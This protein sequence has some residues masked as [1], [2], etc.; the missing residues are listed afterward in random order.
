MAGKF[1]DRLSGMQSQYADSKN[2]YDSMFGGVK[3]PP[4]QY[5]AR[6]Q[7][8]KIVES[9]SSGKLMIRREHVITEG[10]YAGMIAY[11]NMQLETPMGFTFVRRWVERMGYNCPEDPAEIEELCE[12]IAEDAAL[13]KIQIKHS[14]DFV[15]VSVIEALETETATEPEEPKAKPKKAAEPEED[16][17][18]EAGDDD[19][20][21]AGLFEF[22][23]AQ[24]IATEADDTADVLCERI[25]EYKWPE[26][27]M[28]E[29][30]IKLFDEAG[31][32]DAI[33]RAEKPKRS[34][35]KREK[36]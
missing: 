2:Q 32:S 19:A 8:V 15:N 9:N 25:R 7:S 18:A 29:E 5:E 13:V 26:G 24:D 3:I 12:A 10:E 23:K 28:T 16:T 20:T 11:D 17:T 1:K 33:K 4:A 6:V 31:L 14:G 22:C 35:V 27:E 21:L 36:A 34:K 30:E